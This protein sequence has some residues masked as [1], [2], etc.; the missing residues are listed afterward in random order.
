MTPP[1]NESSRDLLHRLLGESLALPPEYRDQL[2]NHL[3][4][5]LHAL[6]EMGANEAQMR[7]FFGAYGSRFKG[8]SAPQP[9]PS[10]TPW[11]QL[12]GQDKAY[13]ALLAQF[14]QQLALHD[15]DTVLREALPVLLP[16]VAAAA[17]HGAIRCAH[18]IESGHLGE[19][20][21]A[22]AYW[23]WRWQG[24]AVPAATPAR[25]SLEQ[26]SAQLIEAA[27]HWHHDGHLIAIRMAAA[28]QSSAYQQLAGALSPAPS[29][30]ALLAGFARFALARYLVSGNFTVLHMITGLRALRVLRPWYNPDQTSQALLSRALTAAYLAANLVEKPSSAPSLPWDVLRERALAA[31][32]DHA[33]KLTHACIDEAQHYGEAGYQLA[34]SRLFA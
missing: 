16:G 9:K 3:P 4:M 5:A 26:W 30:D 32:D 14:Q 13:P 20:A 31:A 22:L 34:A 10:A 25:L 18:A 7:R 27:Q 21:A 11:Q 28:C 12:L 33:I 15:A 19:L 29:F 23:A 6:S 2:T 17:F 8:S 24:L 1:N